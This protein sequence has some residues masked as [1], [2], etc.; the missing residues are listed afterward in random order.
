MTYWGFH[1]DSSCALKSLNIKFL[2]IF[3][4]YRKAK[5]VESTGQVMV[6][7]EVTIH[8]KQKLF[9]GFGANKKQAKSAASK[10][11]LKSFRYSK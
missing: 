3:S 6:P 10:Q 1:L 7:L 8:G 11:A 2:K 4:F 9:H 5:Q